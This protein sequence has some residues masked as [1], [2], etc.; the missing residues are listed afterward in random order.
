VTSRKTDNDE[1][2]R[3]NCLDE[4]E[5]PKTVDC[6]TDKARTPVSIETLK[7]TLNSSPTFKKE[8]TESKLPNATAS[9][10]DN[11]DLHISPERAE[12]EEPAKL[13]T[14]PVDKPPEQTEA[15]TTLS[16]PPIGTL[17]TTVKE[18]P[19]RT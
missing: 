13:T 6:I 11:S 8:A 5:L 9:L 18:L 19:N 7:T 15:P 12:M 3:E 14:P 16:V 2:S 4:I 17:P 10:T 1:P